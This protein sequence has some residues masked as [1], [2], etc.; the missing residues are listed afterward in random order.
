MMDMTELKNMDPRTVDRSTLVQRNMVQ[1][2]AN[3]TKE[4]RLGEYIK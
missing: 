4:E 3:A 1:I 2:D